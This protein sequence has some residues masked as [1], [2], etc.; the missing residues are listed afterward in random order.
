MADNMEDKK[1]RR[2]NVLKN[3]IGWSL[4]ALLLVIVVYL[5][6]DL[7]S[8]G[9]VLEHYASLT[10]T[11][12]SNY[13]KTIIFLS[14]YI[15]ETGDLSIAEALGMSEE[16]AKQL[17]NPD[18]TDTSEET[19]AGGQLASG[20]T[21]EAWKE[22]LSNCGNSAYF[23]VGAGYDILTIDGNDYLV[24]KQGKGYYDYLENSKKSDGTIVSVDDVGCWMFA[25]VNA[26]M[27]LNNTVYSVSDT[28]GIRGN[29]SL[30][31]NSSNYWDYVVNGS[32]QDCSNF[33]VGYG[34]GGN[35]SGVSSYLGIK[36]E[37][38]STSS[39]DADSAWQ[40]VNDNI[41][42]SKDVAIIYCHTRGVT[43]SSTGQGDHWL[44]VV[45]VGSDA[46]G[47]YFEFLGNGTRGH[48]KYT[49]DMTGT[50]AV[51]NIIRISN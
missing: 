38:L 35:E 25:Q 13:N 36:E 27:A 50:G 32:H 44:V 9:E 28:Y 39:R 4:A 46:N 24:C 19:G 33:K 49:N 21:E 7:G 14:S 42:F 47:K 6:I 18:T 15:K 45:G 8:A 11:P 29:I 3:V 16:E 34:T 48:K 26:A 43:C 37:S 31:W 22:A 5:V 1:K 17:L 41:D 12:V 2:N 10:G 23:S 40:Y 51:T 20:K 30:S